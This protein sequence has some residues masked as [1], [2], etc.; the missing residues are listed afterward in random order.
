MDCNHRDKWANQ[1]QESQTAM[2]AC[3]R[4]AKGG[5]R[6]QEGK[7]PPDFFFF[8]FF[9]FSLSE[10]KAMDLN[11]F[12]QT[13][14]SYLSIPP[15]GFGPKKFSKKGKNSLP[16]FKFS[17]KMTFFSKLGRLKIFFQNFST[18]FFFKIF[19]FLTTQI[20]LKNTFFDT[21]FWIFQQ[22]SKFTNFQKKKIKNFKF[23]NKILIKNF[24]KKSQIS[25]SSIN[26]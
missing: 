13:L 9:F 11:F 24:Q 15:Q 1:A 25:N 19:W 26:F 16:N 4:N 12:R 14:G 8:F 20:H 6:T 10:Q 7:A 18:N 3:E 2:N 17:R 21:F 22:I 5:S 23:F